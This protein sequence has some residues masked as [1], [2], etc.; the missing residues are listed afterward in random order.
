MAQSALVLSPGRSHIGLSAISENLSYGGGYV[1]SAIIHRAVLSK[2]STAC[3]RKELAPGQGWM[4][5]GRIHITRPRQNS[6][7]DSDGHCS[8]VHTSEIWRL[9][10]NIIVEAVQQPASRG[11]GVLAGK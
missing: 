7:T 11:P 1:C 9:W 2:I 8:A 5:N 4:L 3:R 10:E 6:E